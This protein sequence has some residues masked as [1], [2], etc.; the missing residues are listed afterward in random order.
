[1]S[2][3]QE[4]TLWQR[5]FEQFMDIWVLPEIDR[6]QA[7]GSLPKP[8]DLQKFQ[9]IWHPDQRPRE[10]RIN[11]EVRA[12]LKVKLRDGVQK[13]EGEDVH[14]CDIEG[15]ETVELPSTEDADCGHAT[16]VKLGDRW[17]GCLDAVYNKG[18]ATIYL[19]KGKE[20]LAAAKYSLDTNATSAF[21]DNLFSAVE[22]FAKAKL[23]LLADF[24]LRE[25]SN[26]KAVAA[27]FNY[28]S[29]LGNV[30]AE[31]R[32]AFN[33]LC[34]SR[35]PARYLDIGEAEINRQ[36]SVNLVAAVESVRDDVVRLA[37]RT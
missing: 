27:R 23:L 31:Q 22:L 6:R 32:D 25:K 29:H 16:F 35:Y 15:I 1:M 18:L 14:L 12:R 26:H 2:K 21:I 37:G 10:I 28:H 17:V 36:Q 8:I 24:Q 9:I 34:Q 5:A 33:K 20:F 7:A 13:T 4:E 11:D 3:E 30:P 19:A